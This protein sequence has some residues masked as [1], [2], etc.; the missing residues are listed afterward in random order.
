MTSEGLFCKAKVTAAASSIDEAS[1]FMLMVGSICVMIS[2]QANV[3]MT[4]AVPCAKASAI[5]ET[6]GS[7]DERAPLYD[8]TAVA[9]STNEGAITGMDSLGSRPSRAS[10]TMTASVR[11]TKA[12]DAMLKSNP[13][14]RTVVVSDVSM[15]VEYRDDWAT[16][17]EANPSAQHA[18]NRRR[19]SKRETSIGRPLPSIR[20]R[21]CAHC[22]IVSS[23][24]QPLFVQKSP[25][26]GNSTQNEGG[27]ESPI[28]PRMGDASRL[29]SGLC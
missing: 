22:P 26:G 20:R 17:N 5:S 3:S 15:A 12:A 23:L 7:T 25:V 18:T 8:N 29:F 10:A 11:T 13:A 28:R 9:A 14:M 21:I 27:V 1:V 2:T 16:L 19:L 24:C 6:T 4:V